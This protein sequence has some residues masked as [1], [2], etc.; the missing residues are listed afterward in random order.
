MTKKKSDFL[1]VLV[2]ILIGVTLILTSILFGT[3]YLKNQNIIVSDV[4]V[5]HDD[6]SPSVIDLADSIIIG[7]PD[8]GIKIIWFVDYD[9]PYVRKFYNTAFKNIKKQFVD[10]NKT[11]FYLK[12]Y[13]QLNIHQLSYNMSKMA[14]CFSYAIILLYIWYLL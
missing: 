4:E 3:I 8:A 1:K 14:L 7:N 2:V 13:P 11:V 5:T 9:S 6:N 12:N 10:T